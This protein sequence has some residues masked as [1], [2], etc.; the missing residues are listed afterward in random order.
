MKRRNSCCRILFLLLMVLSSIAFF[1]EV[2]IQILHAPEEDEH[3]AT[4]FGPKEATFTMVT[5][6]ENFDSSLREEL[7]ENKRSWA[8]KAQRANVLVLHENRSVTRHGVE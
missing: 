8:K 4:C 6:G 5:I 1:I 7:L 2:I 3:L